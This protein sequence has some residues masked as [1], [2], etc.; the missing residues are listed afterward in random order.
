MRFGDREGHAVGPPRPIHLP[1]YV[2][3]ARAGHLPHKDMEPYRDETAISGS[4]KE[5]HLQAAR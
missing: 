3:S 1:G 4:Y 5:A 2:V